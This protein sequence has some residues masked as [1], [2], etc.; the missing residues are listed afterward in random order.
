MLTYNTAHPNPY[1]DLNLLSPDSATLA[2]LGTYYA[3]SP[4]EK[5][6]AA[7]IRRP[8]PTTHP[9]TWSAF[10]TTAAE[11]QRQTLAQIAAARRGD[12]AAFVATLTP[13]QSAQV[14]V[15]DAAHQ[16]GFAAPESCDSLFRIS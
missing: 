8:A 6:L 16:T 10:V 7:I 13:V 1:P 15:S 9:E 5:V 3:A 14:R 4:Y 2:K 12:V 11:L